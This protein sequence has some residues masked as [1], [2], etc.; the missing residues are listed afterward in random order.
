MRKDVYYE[1]RQRETGQEEEEEEEIPR[2]LDT[3]EIGP[4]SSVED[5]KLCVR[6]IA[7][8][9]SLS[10]VG[11]V[12]AN[13]PAPV[14]RLLYYF[15]MTVHNGGERDSGASIGFTDEHSPKNKHVGWEPNTFG[16]HEDDGQ[17][18]HNCGWGLPFGPTYTNG[19]TV[20]AG[21]NNVS[22]DVFFTKNEEFV[23]SFTKDFEGPLFPTIALHSPNEWVVV[24]FGQREFV[25]DIQQL[26][27]DLFQ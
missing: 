14:G 13:C 25:F 15:E 26:G 23:G 10:N 2:Q 20:G 27:R 9:R 22:K 12:Q 4:Y 18:Y 7:Q 19:D 6:N 16:Y 1:Y 11:A 3:S 24:N 21:I 5:D 8:R 17:F